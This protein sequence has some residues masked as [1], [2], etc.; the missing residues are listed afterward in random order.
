MLILQGGAINEELVAREGARVC[1]VECGSRLLE[2]RHSEVEQGTYVQVVVDRFSGGAKATGVLTNER[3]VVVEKWRR[4]WDSVDFSAVRIKAHFWK[5]ERLSH[6]WYPSTTERTNP[7][8]R[9]LRGHC[10]TI[11]RNAD[12]PASGA[13][14]ADQRHFSRAGRCCGG[15]LSYLQWP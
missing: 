6:V 9:P 11:E 4:L 8:L 2:E 12:V 14:M 1:G 10:C 5:R 13:A 7:T 3:S 15:R